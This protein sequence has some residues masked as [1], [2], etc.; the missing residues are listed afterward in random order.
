[1]HER[2]SVLSIY[3]LYFINSSVHALYMTALMTNVCY[4]GYINIKNF[5]HTFSTGLHVECGS[6]GMH[7][8]LILGPLTFF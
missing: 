2:M 4:E 8:G 1:M 6:T 3:I 7:Q 5:M